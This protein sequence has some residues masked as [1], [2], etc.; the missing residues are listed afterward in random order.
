MIVFKPGC[1]ISCYQKVQIRVKVAASNELS[2]ENDRTF[3]WDAKLDLVG[4]LDEMS[5]LL[6]LI[7]FHYD[8]SLT[9]AREA[10][11]NEVKNRSFP[12]KKS[13]LSNSTL[14]DICSYVALDYYLFSFE[15]P[16]ACREKL[17]TNIADM[18]VII[19]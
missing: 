15:P 18:N 17:M 5:G 16:V 7:G 8:E 14:D 10:K 11:D 12:P 9:K 19:Q 1:N 13:M 2:S 6:E 4:D 3:E